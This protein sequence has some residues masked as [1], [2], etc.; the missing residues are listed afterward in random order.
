VL[1]SAH[2]IPTQRVSLCTTFL[3]FSLFGEPFLTIYLNNN[4]I[5][6]LYR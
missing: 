5:H 2:H 1:Q 3:M 6:H 4:N